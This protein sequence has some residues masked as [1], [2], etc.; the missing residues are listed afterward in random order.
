MKT[1][2][3]S[4]IANQQKLG[5]VIYQS[6]RLSFRYAPSWQKSPGAF[7]IS[8]SMPL[9]LNEHP[10][11]T[12]EAY[13]WGLLPDNKT[14]LDQWGKQFQVSSRNVFRL[15]E[16]V[17]EDCAGAIQF[18]PGARENELLELPY[19]EQVTWLTEDELSERM[20]L[21]LQNHGIQRVATDQGQ[22]S[23]AGAQPKIAL[24]QSPES[25][26]WGVPRGQTPT[27]H[28]LKPASNH[29]PG[30]A[31]N[32]HFCLSLAA[33][34]NITT[35]DSAV[36]HT[37]DIPVIVVKRYDRILH[38]SHFIRIHQ[39]DFCQARAIYPHLK[40]QNDGGPSVEDIS[41]VIWDVSS[42]AHH[43]ILTFADALILSFLI[44]GTDAHAKNY[45]LLLAQNNQVR[46]A[47]LYDIASTLPY[48]LEV[49]PHKAKLAMKIGSTYQLK[50]IES[51]HWLT[52]AKQ[53]RLPHARLM[54]R[55]KNMVIQIQTLAPS[56]ASELNS[57]GLNHPVIQ[58][59]SETITQRASYIHSQYFSG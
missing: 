46:L 4:I 21:V 48:P 29:F 11:E 47:P 40:Y 35:T 37:G 45:S 53:L 26:A 32:E 50:K 16:H 2:S 7:P 55:F 54:E 30:F 49:S 39:E 58:K 1:D 28:I 44:A 56:V 22:F 59:L 9:A 14:V 42:D 23:L 25:G 33:A 10:H 15:L 18:I 5:S 8:V 24:Y 19:T 41:N 12:I 51:R 38:G 13:L 20:Q 6:N 36:I 3:L 43:D 57:Q 27:T 52:C 34:L 31:E 17:G